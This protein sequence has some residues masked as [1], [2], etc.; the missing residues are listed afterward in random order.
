[1]ASTNSLPSLLSKL[2]TSLDSAATPIPE[3]STALPPADGISLLDV[4]NELFLS[5]LQNL[6]FLILLKIRRQRPGP[7]ETTDGDANTSSPDGEQASLDDAVVKKLVELRV[8]LDR[9]VKPLEGRMKYQVDKVLR[10]AEIAVQKQ[11]TKKTKSKDG[12]KRDKEAGQDWDASTDSS[13]DSSSSDSEDPIDSLSYRPNAAAFTTQPHPTNKPQKPNS[14]DPTTTAST[15]K[16]S[17]GVYRPPKITPTA[18]PSTD[19]DRTQSSQ[20]RRRQKPTRSTAVD[21]YITH[22]LSTTPLT[23]PSVGSTIVAG[24]RRNQSTKER[25]Q[26]EQRRAYEEANF[27]RLMESKKE[28]RKRSGRERDMMGFGGEELRGLGEGADRIT[29]VTAKG[30]SVK[31]P[32]EDGPRGD[33]LARGTSFGKRR[34]MR[35]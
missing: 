9:G 29:R 5:Y 19:H 31:R 10:A 28:K 3:P 22:E 25:E 11:D 13:S 20:A 4:K 26:D 18:L 32:T 14:K 2:H 15:K 30:G 21:E 33:G 16:D 7:T 24:G 6:V 17:G 1:M 35:R 34:K 12:R 23:E 8:Y 27:T